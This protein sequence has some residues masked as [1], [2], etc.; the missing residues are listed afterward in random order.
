MTDDGRQI[1]DVRLNAYYVKIYPLS[2]DFCSL[3]SDPNGFA[4]SE[5]QFGLLPQRLGQILAAIRL[6][7][8]PMVANGIKVF[9]LI[10]VVGFTGNA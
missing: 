3:I 5:N 7:H 1:T 6:S 8:W 4:H 10:G 2:S 9:I